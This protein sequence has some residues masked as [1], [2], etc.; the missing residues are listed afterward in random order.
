VRNLI[1]EYGAILGLELSEDST[2]ADRWA[3]TESSGGSEYDA[4]GVIPR[5]RPGS[6]I[7]LIMT[8]WLSPVG[9]SLRPRARLWVEMWVE[10]E[11]A[12][13]IQ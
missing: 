10:I 9:C 11:R 4:A 3:L 2:A 8:R 1:I 7:I 12:E 5:L 6:A 13:I